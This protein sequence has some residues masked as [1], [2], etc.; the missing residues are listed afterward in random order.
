MRMILAALMIAAVAAPGAARYRERVPAATPTGKPEHCIPITRIRQSLVRDDQV[1][2]F[3]MLGG[4]VYRNVLPNS[5]PSLGFEQRFTY[6]TTISELC[7]TDI[8]TV[9]YTSPELSRG[10]SCG[11]GQFQQVTLAK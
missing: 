4:K 3:I 11:L 1:I 6:T 2:D 8:I 10:A 5:C 9:L 7:S